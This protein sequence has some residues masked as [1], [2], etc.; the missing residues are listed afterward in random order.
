M[1][2]ANICVTASCEEDMFSFFKV[3]SIIQG[4]GKSGHGTEIKLMVD[5]DGSGRYMFNL[6]KPDGSLEEF[7]SLPERKETIWLGE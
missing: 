6:M 3:C 5:G 1:I 7:P 2:K 4:A